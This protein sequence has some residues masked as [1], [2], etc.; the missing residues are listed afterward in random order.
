M[1]ATS[2]RI[3]TGK[4]EPRNYGILS[5]ESITHMSFSYRAQGGGDWYEAAIVLYQGTP[6]A[7]LEHTIVDVH[8]IR[9]SIITD[10]KM[11]SFTI[12]ADGTYFV[13]FYSGS[14]DRTGGA[15]LGASMQVK[16]FSVST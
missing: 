6:P 9:G 11:E 13:A 7:T 16:G 15:I 12:P 10:F 3:L 8:V 5:S 14:Y 2:S 4:P 1:K